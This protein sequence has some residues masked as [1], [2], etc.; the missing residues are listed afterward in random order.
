MSIIQAN[1][2]D[3]RGGRAFKPGPRRALLGGV[4]GALLLA[5]V[6]VLAL[7]PGGAA[8]RLSGQDLTYGSLPSW[9]PTSARNTAAT[10]PKLEVAN[11]AR[12][13]LDE[14]QGFTVQARLPTGSAD[15]T[16]VGPEFPAYVSNYAQEGLWPAGKAVPSTF[17]VTF[18]AV[19]GT[20]PIAARAFDVL[21]NDGQIVPAK[22][23]VKGGGRVPSVLHG[24]QSITLN[25]ATETLEGQGSIR[26]APEGP[27]V[28][29]GWIYQ[30]ELD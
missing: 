27:K 21:N 16:A 28:L 1:P 14:E 2:S 15:V 18:T 3:D 4:L 12:P 19:K 25:V 24:G 17:Y 29:I 13:V 8:H 6:L 10:K 9:L 30:L 5:T 7:K 11:A 20:I 26:W 23:T 22:L